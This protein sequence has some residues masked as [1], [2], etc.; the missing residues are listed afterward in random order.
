[1]SFATFDYEC[2]CE[3]RPKNHYASSHPWH[4]LDI[5]DKA[6]TE[7]NAVIEIPAKSKVKYELDK[8]TGLLPVWNSAMLYAVWLPR[9]AAFDR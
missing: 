8:E 2:F 9:G 6:P 4:D 5:G 3:Y 1:M 7:V